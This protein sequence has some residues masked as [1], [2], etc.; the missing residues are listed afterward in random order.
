MK[1]AALAETGMM[2]AVGFSAAKIV[3]VGEAG[4]RASRQ[5][6]ACIN[7][8][9]DVSDLL[10]EPKYANTQIYTKNAVRMFYQILKGVGLL[11]Q[12]VQPRGFED[13]KNK[14]NSDILKTG[15]I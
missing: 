4:D 5:L 1:V 6:D 14:E 2:L 11:A 9:K 13:M 10:K 15:D 7:D 8:I 3:A 12:S